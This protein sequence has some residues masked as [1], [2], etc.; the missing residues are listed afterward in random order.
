MHASRFFFAPLMIISA[1]MQHSM[2]QQG[3]E[4]IVQLLPD[5]NGL[6]TRLRDRDYHI[7]EHVRREPC[8]MG[9]ESF[10]HREGQYV[11]RSIFLAILSIEPAHAAIARQFYA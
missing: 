11:R 9:R 8:G 3:N 6:T 2:H 10:S 5:F 4:F 7:A 1:Q